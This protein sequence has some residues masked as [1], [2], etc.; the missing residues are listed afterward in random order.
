MAD[1]QPVIITVVDLISQI[2]F[3]APVVAILSRVLA[4]MTRRKAIPTNYFVSLYLVFFV[5][6]QTVSVYNCSQKI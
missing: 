4:L 2:I 5:Q 3:C 1:M 6:T